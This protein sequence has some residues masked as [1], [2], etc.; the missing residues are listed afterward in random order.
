MDAKN[1]IPFVPAA[2]HSRLA[3]P[4]HGISTDE[5]EH[6][7][8]SLTR[9]PLTLQRNQR[10]RL[11]SV[12]AKARKTSLLQA[13]R[14]LDRVARKLSFRQNARVATYFLA[15]PLLR[16]SFRHADHFDRSRREVQ[17]QATATDTD[18]RSPINAADIEIALYKA[19]QKRLISILKNTIKDLNESSH[20]RSIWNQFYRLRT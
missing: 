12:I 6:R 5:P 18:R 14:T 4:L 8:Q 20:R 13:G 17:A 19:A 11:R 3:G 10:N 15:A 7:R 9:H 1:L 2:R 16:L